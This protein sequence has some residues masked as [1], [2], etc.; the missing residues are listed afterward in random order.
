MGITAEHTVPA[1]RLE[2]WNWHARPGAVT[3][4]TPP[5]LPMTVASEAASLRSG[6]TVFALPAGQRWV[7]QHQHSGYEFAHSFEDVAANQPVRALTKWR[8]RHTFRDSVEDAGST[9]LLDA[10]STPTPAPLLTPAFAYRQR[11]LVGDIAF[12]Q[13][14]PASAPLVIALTGSSGLVGTHLHTQ[15]TTLGHT[16]IPLVRHTAGPGERQWDPDNPHPDLLEGVDAVIH[17]AGESI[18]G[19]F[20]DAKKRRIWDSRVAPTRKLAALAAES[21]VRTF[22]SASA[23]GY[24]GTEAGGSPHTEDAPVGTGFLAEVCQAW[25]EA[26]R[27]EG[28]RTVQIRTG[29]ALSGAGG[30]LPVL[31]ASVSAGLGA[32][33]GSGEFWL[34][35]VSL[36]DLTDT[37]VRALLDHTVSG[38]VNATAAQPVTNAEMS[39][40]LAEVLR[41][42]DVLPIPTFGPK[43]LL[44]SEGAD[45]L[46][47]ADQR[48]DAAV[49]RQRGWVQR[50]PTLRSALD[51]ELGRE[52]LLEA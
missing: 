6:T 8:H 16:V 12:A 26:A 4:L 39:A 9:V 11:Q 17:P 21:G 28:L 34:S 44:G 40:T 15:L 45:E 3:R 36:D 18:M 49:A 1:P 14:L 2:V 23:V 10:V 42:P 47:L 38:P 24:Y 31:K 33:F 29:L 52:D 25:E 27:V 30:L 51:H 20:T 35:W 37:Y 32:R 5:F 19:R 50:Y 43:L 7:A 22:I 41:R 46:A 13:S 48:V